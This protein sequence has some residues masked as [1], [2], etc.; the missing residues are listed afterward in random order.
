MTRAVEKLTDPSGAA[1]HVF[2]ERLVRS[3]PTIE[4]VHL[5]TSHYPSHNFGQLML[6]MVPLIEFGT[7]RRL[8]IFNKTASGMA[9]ADILRYGG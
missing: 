1:D 4:G 9:K 7:L 5:I 3:A 8:P 2:H 6:D